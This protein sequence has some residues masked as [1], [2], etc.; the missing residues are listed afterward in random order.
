MKVELY[1]RIWLWLATV[2][3]VAFLAAVVVG[4]TNH[5]IHPPS[6]VE[7]VDPAKVYSDSE[8]ATALGVT[9]AEGGG[10][11]VRMVARNY[12]FDPQVVR[13]PRGEPVTFRMT[14]P[15]VIH[16]FQVVGTNANAM[17][18]PGYVTQFT[19]VFHR[20]GE[21][22]V[23]CNEYCGLSHHLMQSRLIVEESAE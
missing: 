20:P 5:A 21:Y 22:L 15:D 23:V 3:I 10:V 11:T 4:A 9:P 16:G 17:V 19:T 7:V 12:V 1:E 2:M 8:F 14:S 6:H 13:V 18:I